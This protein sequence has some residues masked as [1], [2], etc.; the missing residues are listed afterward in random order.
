MPY[1]VTLSRACL[2]V[3]LLGALLLVS[4]AEAVAQDLFRGWGNNRFDTEA[5]SAPVVGVAAYGHSYAVLRTD[6]RVIVQGL[7]SLAEAPEPPSGVH[8]TA[9]AISASYPLPWG[10][11]LQ[12]DGQVTTWGPGSLPAPALPVGVRYVQISAGDAHAVALRS[13]GVAVAWGQNSSGQTTL[14]T[15]PPG[16]VVL[17]VQAGNY[18]TLLRLSNGTI[19]GSGWPAYVTVPPLPPGLIYRRLWG[20]SGHVVALRS[21]GSFVAWGNKASGQLLIPAPPAGTTYV[22]FGLGGHHS[23]AL[24]SDDVLVGWGDDSHGQAS[25]P[26]LPLGAIVKEITANANATWVRLASGEVLSFGARTYGADLPAPPSGERWIDHAPG[27]PL[28]GLTSSGQIQQ[29]AAAPYVIPPLLA[30][31]S[32]VAVAGGPTHNVALR[33]DGRVLAWGSNSHG[34]LAIPPLP[35]GMTY[36]SI[37]ATWAR[38]VMLRS[39]GMAIECGSSGALTIPPPPFGTTYVEVDGD[40]ASTMLRCSDDSLVVVAGQGTGQQNVPQLPPGLRYVAVAAMR[41]TCAA[42]RSDGELIVWGSSTSQPSL[43]VGVSC[44]EIDAEYDTLVARLSDGT[45]LGFATSYLHPLAPLPALLPGESIV[46]VAAASNMGV[47]RIGPTAS[48]VTFANGCAGTNSASRLVPRDTPRIARTLEVQVLDLPQNMAVM[49]FGWNAIGPIS[50]AALGMPGCSQ[51]VSLD[52]SVL[53]S[54]TNG[55]AQMSFA[56]PNSM[57]LVGVSFA[58]QALV[59]DLAA[60]PA[61]LVVSDAAM[62]VVGQP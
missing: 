44:V 21:D 7:T 56:V 52:A 36:T 24:R 18:A 51:M 30:G 8:Y 13:D 9:I 46:G 34:Q 43:P 22:Q 37:A 11:A 5:F 41:T 15:V 23:V 3:P 2:V 6:G 27:Y 29:S 33:S 17:Q 19:V 45:A 48:Y 25:P 28:V 38:T 55:S 31:T 39:D 47:A 35:P 20:G 59:L 60:N 42:I 32:Y 62:A 40:W 10:L 14:P 12:S 4:S 57:Q 53:L 50:L 54:G 58:N 61:G 1:P 26:P 49:V 16:V